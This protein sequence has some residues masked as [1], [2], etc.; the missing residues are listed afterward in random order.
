MSI[1]KIKCFVDMVLTKETRIGLTIGQAIAIIITFISF[2]GMWGS[3]ALEVGR[4]KE[5]QFETDKA[6]IQLKLDID[7]NRIERNSQIQQ[8]HD[9]NESA[10]RALMQGQ[11]KIYEYLITGKRV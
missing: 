11:E 6:I 2:F 1:K 9:E 3:F 4:M 5:K 10:H 8:L 7:K